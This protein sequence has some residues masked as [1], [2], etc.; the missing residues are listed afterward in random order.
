[1]SGVLGIITGTIAFIPLKDSSFLSMEWI[2]SYGKLLFIAVNVLAALFLFFYKGAKKT[3]AD[4][5]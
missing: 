4:T 5:K 1:V 2:N 3:D